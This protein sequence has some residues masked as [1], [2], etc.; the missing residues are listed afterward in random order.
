ME[1]ITTIF[2]SV[3]TA[4]NAFSGSLSYALTSIT[5]MFYS[6]ESG[7]TFLGVLLT[8]AMGVGLVYWGFKLIKGLI[9]HRGQ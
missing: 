9:K 1:I 7:L 6:A 5:G 2:N 8:I 4:I 3:G